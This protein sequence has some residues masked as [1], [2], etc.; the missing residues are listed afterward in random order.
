MQADLALSD[1]LVGELFDSD[2]L[3]ISTPMYNFS[4]ADV[5]LQRAQRPEG[6]DRPDRAP[7]VTFDFVSTMASPSTGRCCVASVR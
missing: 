7:R 5:Q 6:L 2:L 4:V 3:V 1:Q